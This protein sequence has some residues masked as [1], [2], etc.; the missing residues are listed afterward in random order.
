MSCNKL[1]QYFGVVLRITFVLAALSLS[2]VAQGKN[3]VILIPGLSGSELKNKITGD[4]VW[5]RTFKSTSDDLRLPISADVTSMH[6]D[7]VPGD[8]IRKVKLGIVPVTD[9]YDG[10]I[11]ALELREGYHEEN[12]DSPSKTAF[13]NSLFVFPYDWRLDNVENARL[14]IRRVEAVKKKLGRPDLK[15]DIVAHSMGGIIARYAAMYGDAELPAGNGKAVPTWAGAKDFDKI[16]LLGTP[17]EG[18]AL[19]LSTLLN[20]FTINGIRID[21]PFVQDSSKYMVFTIP[22][23]YELL[24][25]PGTLRV[26]NEKLEPI[27][28]DIYDPKTWSKYGWNVID[29]KGFATAFDG[30][31]Q[32]IAPEY[33]AHVLARAKQLHEALS[34]APGTSAGISFYVLGADCKQALDSIVVYRDDSKN[35]WKTLLWPKGFTRADGTRVSYADVKKIMW[36]P[37]DGIVTRRSL[38]AASESAVAGVSSIIKGDAPKYICE[39]HNRLAAN[40]AIQNYILRII[41]GVDKGSKEITARQK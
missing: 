29:D 20:G 24:P 1:R 30:A 22:A 35:K 23:A 26:F 28:I 5:F 10:F 40:T 3:P 41:H 32:K 38:E 6:D 25:A 37:G 31:E 4:R 16:I 11:S 18:S 12:W 15:F 27:S 9:V 33:F 2:I 14:L 8:I 19:A 17:N 36:M 34:A 7:L 21:L 13:E 39:E